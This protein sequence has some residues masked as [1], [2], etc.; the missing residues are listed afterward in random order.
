MA[1]PFEQ[2]LQI[3]LWADVRAP[4]SAR[5]LVRQLDWLPE[6]AAEAAALVA[7]ELV[8]NAV[9]HAGPGDADSIGVRLSRASERLMIETELANLGSAEG[10]LRASNTA[11]DEP[12]GPESGLGMAIVAR[13][14]DDWGIDDGSGWASLRI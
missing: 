1:E 14:A 5:Q 4:G 9:A 11:V 3:H 10:R 12:D 2:T 6:P 13:L 7:S 8:S